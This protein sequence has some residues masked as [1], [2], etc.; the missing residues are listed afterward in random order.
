MRVRRFRS[1]RRVCPGGSLVEFAIVMP[2]LTTL[3]VGGVC[4]LIRLVVYAALDDAATQA[5]WAAARGG[6]A[7]DVARVIAASLPFAHPDEVA[8]CVVSGGYH[9]DVI[10]RVV[11]D[12]PVISRMPFFNDQLPPAVAMTTNQQERA[13]AFGL[14]CTIPS[15]RDP[16]AGYSRTQ[17]TA[18]EDSAGAAPPSGR[19]RGPAAW[20]QGGYP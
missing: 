9:E 19:P 4:M 13:F 15:G 14:A 10:A 1:T 12:G 16:F 8:V 17:G 20:P 5:A 6:S 3:I 11:Y 18:E 7:V 2:L